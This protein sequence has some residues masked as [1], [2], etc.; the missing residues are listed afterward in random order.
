LKDLDLEKIREKNLESSEYDP[1]CSSD[2]KDMK[3]FI[4]K[5]KKKGAENLVMSTIT[6]IQARKNKTFA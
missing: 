2:F 5:Q 1:K 3:N 4:K 6:G